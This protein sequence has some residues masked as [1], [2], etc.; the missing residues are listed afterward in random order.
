MVNFFRK[1]ELHDEIMYLLSLP[2]EPD[3]T[4][5]SIVKGVGWM[6]GDWGGV[7]IY[8]AGTLTGIN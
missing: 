4:F 5:L 1:M 3:P 2:L 7:W 8:L 6:W